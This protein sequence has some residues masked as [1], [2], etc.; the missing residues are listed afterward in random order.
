MKIC[1]T[2]T[3]A[4]DTLET[5][6][7]KKER[8]LGGSSNY[9]SIASSLFTD[10][11]LCAHVGSDFPITHLKALNKRGIGTGNV[12]VDAKGLTFHWAGRYE[13]AMNE[14]HTI[15]THLNVLT[16]FNP[17]ICEKAKAC[18][19]LFLANVDPVIQL[20]VI[21]QAKKGKAKVVITDTMNYWIHSKLD[22][23]KEVLKRTD[24]LII[25]ENE[26]RLL[27]NGE[28]NVLKAGDAVLKMGPKFLIVKRGE[29]GSMVFDK[30]GKV[31]LVPAYPL[32]TVVDP[33]GAGDTFAGGFTG[34]IATQK[35][36][37][38]IKKI[39]KAM[40]YGSV[41]ASFTVQEFGIDGLMKTKK[42]QVDKRF[43]EL[44]EICKV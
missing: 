43:K 37:L 16:D 12:S 19:V 17:N 9:F 39:R 38:D 31:Y 32:R 5:P 25:N 34:Y 42:A 29:Y 8:I 26:V 1:V 24:V 4:F 2:G 41:C 33:T 44:V 11:E 7:G 23:L 36:P 3:L 10:V 40:M 35:L 14:A 6:F 20:K 22:A 27:A 13:G 21:E 28:L 18:E 30:K 15:D